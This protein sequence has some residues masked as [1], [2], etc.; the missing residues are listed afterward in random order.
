MTIEALSKIE[1]EILAEAQ[2]DARKKIEE[3]EKYIKEMVD[4]AKAEAEK[5]ALILQNKVKAD[6]EILE[7]KRISETRRASSLQILKTKNEL[8]NKAFNE[9]LHD[10]KEIVKKDIYVKS[11]IKLLNSSI[12]QIGSEDLKIK[13]NRED[14]KHWPKIQEGLKLPPNIK[15]TVDKTPIS[16]TGGFIISTLD[17]RVKIDNTFEARLSYVEKNM[18]K[19]IAQILF[20]S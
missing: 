13:L 17:E 2:L 7:R 4:K 14:H 12:L 6:S 8:I 10:L 9:A 15:L 19:E 1:E 3:A 5:E 16:T 18:K 11:L 20:S